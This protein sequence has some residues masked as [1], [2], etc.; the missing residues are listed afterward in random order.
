MQPIIEYAEEEL[1]EFVATR[2]QLEKL[3]AKI[4][5]ISCVKGKTTK[6]VS[7]LTP[8]CPSGFKKK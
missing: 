2:Y 8:K 5:T 6:K 7:G 4:K 3:A 1:G